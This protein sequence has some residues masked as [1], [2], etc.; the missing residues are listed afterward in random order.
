MSEAS[1]GL[2]LSN[3]W[4]N[5]QRRLTA[6]ERL[7]DAGTFR[8]LDGIGIAA[9]M[10]C[11]EL[12]GGGG[13][14]ARWMA[15]RVGPSGSV[16]VTDIDVSAL[17]E[18]KGP[19]ID[20]R[21]HDI[22]L[23]P[24]DRD[25]FDI[26]HARLVLEHLPTR[27]S[28]LDKLTSALRPGAWLVVEDIDLS[29]WLY[30]PEERLLFEPHA[31]RA[32]YQRAVRAAVAR[33]TTSGV[34][35]EFGRNLPVHLNNAGLEHVGGEMSGPLILGGTPQADFITLGF[36]QLATVWVESGL[37]KTDV[38]DVIDAFEKPGSLLSQYYMASAWGRRPG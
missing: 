10:R 22:C 8:Y 19:N 25:A 15:D 26:I 29:D 18:C 21:V 27:L 11:L 6:A 34:D 33:G 13:S 14:V 28:V 17:A 31:L 30:L 2:G 3:T 16:L 37:A 35:F 24:L 9:G 23:D 1:Y 38:D 36:R 20:V 32:T 4:S 5:E 7:F 12:G